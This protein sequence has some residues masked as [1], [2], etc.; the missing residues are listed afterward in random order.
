MVSECSGQMPIFQ[1]QVSFAASSPLSDFMMCHVA[2][3]SVSR[4]CLAVES[5]LEYCRQPFV[6]LL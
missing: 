3:A 1:A 5:Q 6:S 2:G 4:A